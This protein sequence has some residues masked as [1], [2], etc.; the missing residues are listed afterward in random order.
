[1][2]EAK[3]RK[4]NELGFGRPKRGL[5]VSPPIEIDGSSLYVR[6]NKLDR[7]ELRAWLL[8]FDRLVWPSSRAIHLASGPDEHFLEQC[9]ILTRP[10][11][12]VWGDGAQGI[13]EGQ[14][15]AFH[16][17]DLKAPGLW[18][19][20]QGENSLLIRDKVLEPECGIALNFYNA[21]PV[22]N[23][24]VPLQ[25]ILEF[26]RKR[27]D[28]LERLRAE[29]DGFVDSVSAADDKETEIK[30]HSKTIDCA[31]A[32]AI[33]VCHEW[34]FPVRLTNFKAS[35]EIRPFVN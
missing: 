6:S 2:G 30:K 34:Q 3:R 32:D 19:L 20:A 10:E 16:D 11:Y 26:K 31:C 35:F 12:T 22:P 25:E 27:F 17:L 8:F 15:R 1:M 9:G 23:Q 21:I 5:V 4:A 24:D 14:M 33:R 18:A 7:Q 13:A 28:E 29:I